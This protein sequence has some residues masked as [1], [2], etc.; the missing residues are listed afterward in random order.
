[1]GRGRALEILVSDALP[2]AALSYARRIE[3]LTGTRISVLSVGPERDQ[4][5]RLPA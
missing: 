4:M 1:M 2:D 3:A 5:M